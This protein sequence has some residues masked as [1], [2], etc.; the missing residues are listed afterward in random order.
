MTRWL[1]SYSRYD[2]ITCYCLLLACGRSNASMASLESV[3]P[4]CQL[5]LPSIHTHSDAIGDKEGVVPLVL[6]QNSGPPLQN[7]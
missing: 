4:K 6:V 2:E 1:D 7:N 5:R 3:H